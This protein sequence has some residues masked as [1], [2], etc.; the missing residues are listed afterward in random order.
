MEEQVRQIETKTTFYLHVQLA[1]KFHLEINKMNLSF[2]TKLFLNLNG[3][4]VFTKYWHDMRKVGLCF[5]KGNCKD[6]TDER[7]KI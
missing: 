2:L 3:L 1:K 4:N 5:S 6:K 7:R